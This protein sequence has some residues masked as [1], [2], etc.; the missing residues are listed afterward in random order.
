VDNISKQVVT[1]T[2]F[3]RLL[4]RNVVVFLNMVIEN[5]KWIVI[6]LIIVGTYM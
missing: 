3:Y 5:V 6:K 1:K 2:T 4:V